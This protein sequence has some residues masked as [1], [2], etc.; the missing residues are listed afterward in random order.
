[1]LENNCEINLIKYYKIEK[2][3]I[4]CNFRPIT[5]SFKKYFSTYT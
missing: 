5:T 2:N 4:K 3:R 1:M